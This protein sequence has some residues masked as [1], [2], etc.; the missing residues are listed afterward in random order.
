MSILSL[1]LA[2]FRLPPLHLPELT[3]DSHDTEE[4]EVE[5]PG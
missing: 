2:E 5:L 1:R 4:A 3:V